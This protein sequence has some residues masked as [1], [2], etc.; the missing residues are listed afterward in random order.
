MALSPPTSGV[1]L[2][3]RRQLFGKKRKGVRKNGKVPVCVTVLPQDHGVVPLLGRRTW[4]LHTLAA[5]SLAGLSISDRT[6]S[7]AVVS[8][9]GL[10]PML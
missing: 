9:S 6:E 1:K 5:V 10:S 4:S 7:Y 8:L 2:G 3:P